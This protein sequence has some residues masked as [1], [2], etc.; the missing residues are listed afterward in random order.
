MRLGSFAD[1]GFPSILR[2]F[3]RN[4]IPSNPLRQESSNKA[5]HPHR[6]LPDHEQWERRIKRERLLTSKRAQKHN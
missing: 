2:F 6:L 4:V 3:A 5:F 1:E